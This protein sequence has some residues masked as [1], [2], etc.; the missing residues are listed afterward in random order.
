MRNNIIIDNYN[1]WFQ[2]NENQK[3]LSQT[4]AY[5]TNQST[6]Q[7]NNIISLFSN[8]FENSLLNHQNGFEK[9]SI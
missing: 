4:A 8:I 9:D 7:N 1:T 2:E 6:Y 5:N 3:Y